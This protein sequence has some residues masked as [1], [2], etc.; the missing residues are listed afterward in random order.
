MMKTS[1]QPID[2]K[3]IKRFAVAAREKLI[4]GVTQRA[5]R[6][7]ISHD[8]ERGDTLPAP[9]QVK[10]DQRLP[11]DEIQRKQY[12]SLYRKIKQTDL[13]SVIEEIAYTWFN[14]F[15][16][17]RFM[18]VND[19]LPTGVRVLSSIEGKSEPDILRNIELVTDELQL[20]RDKVYDYQ[21]R[22][23]RNASDQLYKYL[24]IQQC[25]ELHRMMPGIFEPIDDTSEILLPDN[26][27]KDD[28]VINHMVHDI[29]EED[30]TQQVEIIG[31]L[32]QFYIS[33]EKEQVYADLKKNIKIGKREL[34]PAT[35]LFTPKWIVQ[36][37][38]ENSLGRLWLESHPD[39]DLRK[40]WHYYLDEAK[41]EPAVQ[42]HLD[43]L[44]NRR[45]NP[46]T[47][48]FL[49]PCMGSGHILVY[50]F[51]VFFAIYQEAG[52]AV[53]DIPQLILEHNIYGLEIDERARQ[54]AYFSLMMKARH[55]DRQFFNKSVQV[56][57]Y[58]IEESNSI[59]N[60]EID[61]VTGDQ[62]DRDTVV[63]LVDLFRDAKLFGAMINVP[64]DLP[65]NLIA[66]RLKAIR[67][68]QPGNIFTEEFQQQNLRLF[69][70]LIKQAQ[71]LTTKFDIIVTNPPYMG[72]KGMNDQLSKYIKKHYPNEKAD[73]FA[74]MMHKCTS[75][76]KVSG[77]ISMITQ[78]SWMFLS[79][80]EKLRER[81]LQ[82]QQIYSLV[83]LG[84]RAFAEISGEVVQSTMFILRNPKVKN[85]RAIYIR[86]VDI[87]QAE[88][89]AR[90]F[91]NT[92]FYYV[93]SQ[94]DFSD[95]PG[96]PIAYWA[97]DQVRKIFRENP[98]LRDVAELKHGMST[99]NNEKMLRRWFEVAK[100]TIAFQSNS[101]IEFE[102][103]NKTYVP[104]NKGGFFKKWYGN[105]EY[106]LRYDEVGQRLM[107]TFE[108]FR[109]D[110]KKYY[111][112]EGISWSK[113]TTG[114]FSTRFI[115]S[116]SIFSDAGMMLFSNHLF[117]IL[118]YMNSVIINKFMKILNPTIN[119]SNGTVSN[120]P[121]INIESSSQVEE[122]C[123]IVKINIHISKSDWDSFEMSWDFQQHPF[124]QFR[125]GATTIAEAYHN[126]AVE[127]DR[128]FRTLKA[129]E[130][131]LNRIFINL[132]GLQDELTP[133]ESDEEVTVRRADRERDVKSFL[134][135]CVGLMFGRYS[136]DEPG[137][138][139]AGGEFDRHRYQ[140]YRPD[141]DNV[142]PITD[143]AYFADDIVGRLLTLL[144]LI[145][146]E[147][148]LEENLAFIAAALKKRATETARQRIRR[149]FLKEFY[150]DHVKTYKK[151]PIYWLFDSGRQNGFKALIYLHRYQPDLV[152]R[153]RIDYLHAMERKY[154]EA[155][156]QAD[157]QLEA[158][159][160]ARAQLKAHKRRDQLQKQLVECRQ[161]DQV[162][163]HVANLQIPL[164]L[165][166]GVKVNYAKFQQIRVPGRDEAVDLLAKI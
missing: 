146:G 6:F 111:F 69:D 32:Y 63:K 68:S 137:L 66:N 34:P 142:I 19:Y 58:A 136:L 125:N 21:D 25:H 143:E 100:E 55:Y 162:V 157:L 138:I 165:D 35:Q 106:I 113:V 155:M 166:D 36:Y 8:K 74:V 30:W 105:V 50:A 11:L 114:L 129:N 17:L 85:Y 3:A 12:R 161:Y 43:A 141:A 75:M 103:T 154:E 10:F 72:R 127:A 54:L 1:E 73:L 152:A 124:L 97:S 38:V 47:I 64:D 14:R 116:G 94:N 112:R 158:D 13:K 156:K 28:S 99:G 140:T 144:K 16:A 67:E 22:R 60:E 115:N 52:Y 27:L 153:L 49:D 79:S 62:V 104:F 90:A 70:N 44:K 53:R 37:M 134:S 110:N 98:K 91:F 31:W 160:S 9:E 5:L 139:Y 88:A 93:R 89:K 48:K 107:N 118:G 119:S 108:G 95:I 96:S 101:L 59:T 7:G 40:Q 102:D 120:L 46:E 151:R 61:L 84:T 122:I 78:Q 42:K 24:L 148:S 26:L 159:P 23:D 65:I 83:H 145:F 56:H 18:E 77:L 51:N 117:I 135:Y 126:W 57:V 150:P 71:L 121:I 130:E 80:F 149:Y 81:L 33:E 45:L 4:D 29:D 123:S 86:L 133:E 147:A 128:R 163:A 109:H 87:N 131:E 76:V 20:D 132:Y 39:S 15:I 82:N 164:D 92:N 41:Q 2:K